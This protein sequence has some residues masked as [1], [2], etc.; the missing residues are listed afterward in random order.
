MVQLIKELFIEMRLKMK[1]IIDL[2]L[3]ILLCLI[4]TTIFILAINQKNTM[5]FV[6]MYWFFNSIKLWLL[7]KKEQ[8]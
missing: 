4:A 7:L 5:I 2:I 8:A 3:S 1:K 6:S